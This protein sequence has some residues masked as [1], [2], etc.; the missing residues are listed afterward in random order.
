M[1]R[2]VVPAGA[3]FLEIAGSSFPSSRNDPRITREDS[4]RRLI[5]GIEFR[6]LQARHGTG[7]PT[8]IWL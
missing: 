3:N 7:N 2:M 1:K 6:R 4:E 5:E 8:R